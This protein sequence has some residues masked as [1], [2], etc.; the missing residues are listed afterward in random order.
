MTIPEWTKP[1]IGK[2]RPILADE[3]RAILAMA[4]KTERAFHVA[5]HGNIDVR[6][7]HPARLKLSNHKA[8]HDF[9]ATYHGNRL[10]RT[11]L[12]G[13]EQVGNYA[14]IASPA[15]VPGIHGDVDVGF[16][17]FCPRR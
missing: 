6:T 12:D 9:R 16:R 11:N 14:H 15:L 17:L 4:A 5:L 1:V 8:H 13:T 2:D 10:L 7:R 3:I